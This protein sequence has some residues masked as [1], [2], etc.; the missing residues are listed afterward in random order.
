M[1]Y[2]ELIVIYGKISPTMNGYIERTYMNRYERMLERYEAEEK[3]YDLY[4]DLW[5]FHVI[6]WQENYGKFG[7][8][9]LY[10]FYML[11]G[12]SWG[13][14]PPC[15]PGNRLVHQGFVIGESSPFM[16]YLFRLV[17]YYHPDI[18]E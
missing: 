17:K 16:A 6:Y 4:G 1:L 15:S 12:K 18:S 10:V 13:F 11:D 14:G 2:Y 9:F 3:T 8:A 5:E 7:D